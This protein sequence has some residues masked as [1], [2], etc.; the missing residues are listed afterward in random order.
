MSL[1]N[2]TSF[3][4]GGWK[5]GVTINGVPMAMSHQGNTIWVDSNADSTLARG[6]EKHPCASVDDALDYCLADRG[7][8][9]LMKPGHVETLAVAD[10]L[11]LDIDGVAIVGLG[12][13]SKQATF[14][15]TADA[16]QSI[17]ASNVSL[18][19]IWFWANF[20]NVDKAL[21]VDAGAHYLTIEG[22]RIY[23]PIAGSLNFEEFLAVA[24][25]ANFLTLRNNFFVTT[26][27]ESIV[28]LEGECINF[29]CIGNTF[30]CNSTIA[31]IKATAAAQ[32]GT[33]VFMDNVM[34]NWD[35]TTDICVEIKTTTVAAIV[36]ESAGQTSAAFGA[37]YTGKD[38]SH[39]LDC[40]ETDLVNIGSIEMGASATAW[41]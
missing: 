3:H 38:V 9:I 35:G 36:R 7:D 21:D 5:G 29:A 25:A 15:W 41:T 1:A 39:C 11:V 23:D 40:E 30:C 13:G 14:K 24:A 10:D 17:T 34:A 4:G 18:V 20:A 26:A 31:I 6:T 37:A 28:T 2:A 12:T 33:P 32:L 16:A 22:C 19:N 27:G 8:V